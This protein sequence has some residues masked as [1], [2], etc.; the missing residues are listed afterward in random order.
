MLKTR[1]LYM[2]S[3]CFKATPTRLPRWGPRRSGG[4]SLI[5]FGQD[6]IEYE[7]QIVRQR[8]LEFH[9]TPVGRVNEGEAARVQERPVEREQRPEIARHA[10][11]QSAVDTV[12]DDGVADLAQVH[13]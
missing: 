11:A 10:P 2:T 8:R 9:L 3:D 13:P 5:V 1:P 4:A 12:P 7:L 6:L